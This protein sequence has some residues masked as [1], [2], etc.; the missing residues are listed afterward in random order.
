MTAG[1]PTLCG[2]LRPRGGKQPHRVQQL[3]ARFRGTARLR[4]RV[5]GLKGQ[6]HKIGFG[7]FLLPV[8]IGLRF[9][10]KR[11]APIKNMVSL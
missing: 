3:A 8:W 2:C 9:N 1:Q 10:A 6:A 11:L 7:V 5:K 4:L